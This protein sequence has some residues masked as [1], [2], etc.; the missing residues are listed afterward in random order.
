MLGSRYLVFITVGKSENVTEMRCRKEDL[1]LYAFGFDRIGILLSD[2]YFIDPDPAEGQGE[3]AERGVRLELRV[4]DREPLKGSI[5]SAQPIS[6]GQ[7]IW[8]VDLL[9]SVEGTPGSLD[10]VHHHPAFTGWEPGHRVYDRELSQDPIRWLA[11]K[12]SDLPG[13]LKDAG[14]SVDIAG[15]DDAEAV[16]RAAPEILEATEELLGKVR[17]G[18]AGLAPA[19]PAEFRVGWL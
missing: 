8:R 12:L 13:V 1:M 10:R 2:L 6:A 16:R 18:Q 3:G 7:P 14:V 4:L 19:D 11:A 17:R 15:P 5:Y 9:E